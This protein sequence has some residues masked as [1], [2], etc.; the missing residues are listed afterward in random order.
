[1]AQV[2]GR[3]LV[4]SCSTRTS[5]MSRH[6][7]SGLMSVLDAPTPWNQVAVRSAAHRA[8]QSVP[9]P[10]SHT[11]RVSSRRR[12]AQHPRSWCQSA[13]RCPELPPASA[14]FCALLILISCGCPPVIIPRS[15]HQ[16]HTHHQHSQLHTQHPPN[17]R[18]GAA[19]LYPRHS[20]PATP[21]LGLRQGLA[22]SR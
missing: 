11:V 20:A 12:P 16:H 22:R 9:R 2:P 8:R 18:R 7:Q 5:D 10:S 17:R 1:M 15:P 6:R 21:R 4:C 19:S 13:R 3:V 14:I